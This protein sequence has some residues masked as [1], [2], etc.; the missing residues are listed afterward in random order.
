MPIALLL[1]ILIGALS[2]LSSVVRVVNA[3]KEIFEAA[4]SEGRDTLTPEEHARLS[5]L[6]DESDSEW[7]EVYEEITR[8]LD[9]PFPSA[10]SE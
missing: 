7:L 8:E 9:A 3:I 10:P 6:M 1:P 5:D 4:K 2:Q